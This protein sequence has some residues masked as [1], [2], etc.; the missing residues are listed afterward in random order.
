MTGRTGLRRINP[1]IRW[2]VAP[3][4]DSLFY[5]SSALLRHVYG[6]ERST[7]ASGELHGIVIRPEVDEEA[8]RLVVEHMIVDRSDLDTIAP[9]RL[10]ERDDF[11]CERDEIA[12]D[13]GLSGASRLDV[14]GDRRTH[15]AGDNDSVRL[16]FIGARHAEGVDTAVVAPFE[17]ER[18]IDRRRI[19]AEI[20]RCRCTQSIEPS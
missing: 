15:R 1:V 4:C 7:Q 9:Q 10:Q 2:P 16:D 13:R 12:G 8:P 17:P 20:R 5:P 18:V 19:E 14:Y 3:H 11:A 6:V